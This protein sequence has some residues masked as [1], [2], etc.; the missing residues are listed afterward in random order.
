MSE[1]SRFYPKIL[2]SQ[3]ARIGFTLTTL[4]LE[5]IKGSFDYTSK[6]K[7]FEETRK[8]DVFIFQPA[9]YE[10]EFNYVSDVRK[11]INFRSGIEYSSGIN[12][13][14]DENFNEIQ[15]DL[16]S[17]FRVSD[18]FKI[19]LGISNGLSNN[20]IGYVYNDN[21][22]IYFGNRKVK[23][24]ENNLS[25]NYNF[26]SYKS[27]E[28]KFRQFW[29]SAL[30]KENFFK[31]KDD[32]NRS[33]S[34]KKISDYDPNTNF[35]LWNLDLSYDWEFS[36]GSKLTLLYRNNIFNEDNLSGISYYR[37]TK[38]LFEN[39]INH[40]F[41]LRVNYFIDYNLLKKKKI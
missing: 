23:F 28:L 27:L 33:V 34:E 30:Y 35:N 6:Y 15:L 37:S 12:E 8:D 18:K 13:Q 7:D 9:I 14:F 16:Y 3:G 2:K 4:K 24:M 31:L 22:N 11:R 21:D 32:G 26:N 17:L 20:E 41:S 39:P 36:P 40:Q 38:E 25:L 1:R 5:E 10:L 29:S 19:E